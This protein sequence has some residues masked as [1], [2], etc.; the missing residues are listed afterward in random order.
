MAEDK[1]TDLRS[2][3]PPDDLKTTAV[4]FITKDEVKEIL[5]AHAADTDEKIDQL[6]KDTN[7]KIDTV[8]SITLNTNQTVQQLKLSFASIRTSQ[9]LATLFTGVFVTILMKIINHFF[10]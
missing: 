4:I 8:Q 2:I 6:R 1:E 7:E 3:D 10:K 5:I 9:N